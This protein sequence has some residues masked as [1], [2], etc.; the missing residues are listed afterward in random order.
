MAAWSAWGRVCRYCSVVVSRA[1]PMRSLTVWRSAPPASSQ[2]AWAWRRSW[3]RTWNGS[4][5]V[6]RAGCQ[7]C[8]RNQARGCA[9]RRRW[10]PRCQ[11][12]CWRVVRLGWGRRRWL[13]V[14]L[15]R[16]HRPRG[17]VHSGSVRWQ[18]QA[19]PPRRPRRPHPRPTHVAGKRPG[20][21]LFPAPPP[22]DKQQ[23]EPPGVSG[24]SSF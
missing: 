9:D 15:G 8:W 6:L 10:R 21:L 3:T 13:G 23:A 20:D 19:T 11:R 16:W 12:R 1:W 7:I 17:S 2:D 24:G 4:P 5:A 18:R 22:Q 14:G